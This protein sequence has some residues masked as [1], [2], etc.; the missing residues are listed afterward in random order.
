MTVE[1]VTHI[2]DLNNSYPAAGDARSEG[3]DHIRNIKT[4]LKTDFPN[5]NGAVS[6]TDEELSGLTLAN[7]AD[8]AASGTP[9]AN[10]TPSLTLRKITKDFAQLQGLVTAT[11][12]AAAGIFT[13]QAGYRPAATVYAPATFVDISTGI[14]YAGY[15]QI[16]AIG[17]V[18]F[19]SGSATPWPAAVNDFIMFN[20]TYKLA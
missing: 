12:A 17:V 8:V 10:W 14:A 13:A 15:V 1:S 6:S 9:A 20:I 5:I 11:G 2:S 18:S 16:S 19:F 3:D 7:L 4:A